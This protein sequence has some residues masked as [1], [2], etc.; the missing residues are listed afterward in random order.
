MRVYSKLYARKGS[1]KDGVKDDGGSLD[2]LSNPHLLQ[3]LFSHKKTLN[4]MFDDRF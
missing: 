4:W 2:N 1:Q 3:I